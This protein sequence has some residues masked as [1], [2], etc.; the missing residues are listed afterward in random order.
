MVSL[1]MAPALTQ[2]FV[3]SIKEECLRPL[4]AVSPSP[5]SVPDFSGFRIKRRG[6]AFGAAVRHRNRDRGDGDCCDALVLCDSDLSC[7]GY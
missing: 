2:R 6:V 5:Y 7:C 3:R 4:M 1:P